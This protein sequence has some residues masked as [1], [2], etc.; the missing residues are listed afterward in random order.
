MSVPSVSLC[1]PTYN[2]APYLEECMTSATEQTYRDIEIIVVDD[3]SSDET[4]A[5]VGK[6]A[7]GDPRIRV[8]Q[9]P[10]RLGLTGNWNRCVELARGEWI[11]FVFQDDFIEPHCLERL[12]EAGRRTEAGMVACFRRIALE[13]ADEPTRRIYEK[14]VERE[15]LAGVFPGKTEVSAGEFCHAVLDH[16]KKNFVGEPTAVLL[17]RT[18][19]QRFG[20]FNPHLVSLCDLEYWIRV[21]IHEGIAIVPEPLATFRVHPAGASFVYRRDLRYR[22]EKLDSLI[23]LHEFVFNEV[24]APLRTAAAD[25]HPPINLKELF[26]RQALAAWWAAGRRHT[27]GDP[28]PH[29]MAE[30]RAVSSEFP[31]VQKVRPVR[32]ARL[33]RS[34]GWYQLRRLLTSLRSV[35]DGDRRDRRE[36]P[37]SPQDEK[38]LRVGET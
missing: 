19:F 2:G 16:M 31:R 21:G 7:V 6:H 10:R 8:E 32:R 33:L 17:H 9:N 29:R 13:D 37:G 24:F 12:V 15:S 18:A 36:V 11:K 38:P 35:H 1:I 14:Y 23:L 34:L 27:R 5:I 4:L 30:W 26:A 3:Q 28:K 20:I 25:R 22:L